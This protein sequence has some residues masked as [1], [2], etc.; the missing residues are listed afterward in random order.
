M[1][2]F[3]PLLLASAL[4]W[5]F[6]GNWAALL[7]LAGGTVYYAVT[8]YRVSHYTRTQRQKGEDLEDRVIYIV[9]WAVLAVLGLFVGVLFLNGIGFLAPV[10]IVLY[11]VRNYKKIYRG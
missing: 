4:V 9:K 3:F 5:M 10:L 8:Q 6:F 2:F 7:L 1:S 11:A